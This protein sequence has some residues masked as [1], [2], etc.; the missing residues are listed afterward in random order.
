MFCHGFWS[1]DICKNVMPEW[2][3]EE[4]K[5]IKEG[6]KRKTIQIS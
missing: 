3:T 4:K 6:E 5:K 2:N 1:L